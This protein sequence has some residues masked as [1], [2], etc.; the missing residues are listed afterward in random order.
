[1]P[2]CNEEKGK[3]G[4]LGIAYA[5]VLLHEE[6]FENIFRRE[7]TLKGFGILTRHHFQ[8]RSGVRRL[9]S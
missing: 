4:Y 6:A 2:S 9:N 1:M 7:L 3:V 8:V 5:D